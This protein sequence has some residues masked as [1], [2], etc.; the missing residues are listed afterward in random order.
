M[1]HPTGALVTAG[2]Q[3]MNRYTA[4][5]GRS[6]TSFTPM[7]IPRSGIQAQW[8]GRPTRCRLNDATHPPIQTDDARRN[9]PGWHAD[10]V[11]TNPPFG[12]KSSITIVNEEGIPIARRS[13]TIVPASGRRPR[14]AAHLRPVDEGCVEPERAGILPCAGPGGEWHRSLTRAR[15]WAR[16]FAW[17]I[18]HKLRNENFSNV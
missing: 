14:P 18:H 1:G 5:L 17:S 7:M 3:S 12:K 2:A 13:P 11:V 9:E 10:V 16:V 15:V 4:L 6:I 8:Q